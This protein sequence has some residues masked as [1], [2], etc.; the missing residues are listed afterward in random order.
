MDRLKTAILDGTILPGEA[1]NDQDMQEWLQVSRT[2]IREA[3]N[4]LSRSGLVEMAAQRY[5]R[6]VC[7]DP[8]RHPATMQA[9]GA[10]L[11][12][13]A[14]VSVPELTAPHRDKLVTLAA[15]VAEATTGVEASATTSAR[16]RFS[17]ALLESC[18]N[19][20]LVT[21]FAEALDGL[22]YRVHIARVADPS[23]PVEDAE[24]FYDFSRALLKL[25][26]PA[27]LMSLARAY[28]LRT[29]LSA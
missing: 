13:V 6:V 3:L 9:L 8:R 20:E 22:N 19:A 17:A 7:A 16:A 23:A 1:L 12:A 10:T 2:P 26:D 15:D 5:T 21:A 11:L 28:N 14:S 25:D 29:S 24:A 27:A 4:D 18:P